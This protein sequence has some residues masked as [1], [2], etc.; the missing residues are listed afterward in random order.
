[1]WM[2]RKLILTWDD[3]S[4]WPSGFKSRISKKLER[5]RS[6][7]KKGKNQHFSVHWTIG[8]I[9]GGSYCATIS[10]SEVTLPKWSSGHHMIQLGLCDPGDHLWGTTWLIDSLINPFM[11][12]VWFDNTMWLTMSHPTR[13]QLVGRVIRALLM[14]WCCLHDLEQSS[15]WSSLIELVI[16]WLS[17]YGTPY[18]P[19]RLLLTGVSYGEEYFGIF[20]TSLYR[21]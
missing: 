9:P 21:N 8:L 20:S 1:M 5:S 18:D 11:C 12:V 2:H 13:H 17:L 6:N 16:G 7:F 4:K 14:I 19:M 3:D 10:Q 15:A